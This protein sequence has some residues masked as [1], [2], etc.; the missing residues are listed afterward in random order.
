MSK[1][2]QDTWKRFCS[3]YG[4]D[5]VERKFGLRAPDDW[6]EVLDAVDRDQLPLVLAE[7]KSKFPTWMP[8][9]PEF[10]A[11][12]T[13]FSKPA[14]PDFGPS[15]QERLINFV[16]ANRSLTPRQLGM[17]WQYIPERFDAVPY[18]QKGMVRD[19]GVRIVG[20]IVPAD[21]DHLG[22]RVMVEDLQQAAA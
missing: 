14:A 17:P 11:L 12:V 2:A 9:L 19:W 15:M 6:V 20:V 22:Y 21:G 8:G 7:T 3:W 13:Q 10:E 4:A 1:Q 18:G 16:I 5:A